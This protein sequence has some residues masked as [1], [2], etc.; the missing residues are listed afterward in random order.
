MRY[1]IPVLLAALAGCTPVPYT[2]EPPAVAWV[3]KRSLESTTTC[4]LTAMNAMP[5]PVA[6]TSAVPGHFVKIVE[7][8][9]IN[10]VVPPEKDVVLGPPYRVRLTQLSA[11]ETVINI[12]GKPEW[13]GA[14]VPIGNRCAGTG[15]VPVR[16]G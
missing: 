13:I 3:A 9:Y 12:Y 16:L 8:G 2:D 6:A 7:R 5:V 11:R 10:D 1:A 14:L 15:P 4:V